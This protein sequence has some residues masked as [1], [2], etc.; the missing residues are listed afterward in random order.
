MRLRTRRAKYLAAIAA[1]A[2]LAASAA[3]AAVSSAATSAAAC[4][5]QYTVQNQWSTGFSLA[6][7]VT[8][9]GSPVTS[10]TLGYSYAGNQQLTEGWD[11]TWSQSGKNVTL[12]SA[13][14]N[15]S[16]G[17][18]GRTSAGANFSYSGT[19]A[20][21]TAFTLNGTTCST[22]AGPAPSP[23]PAPTATAEPTATAT[24]TPAPTATAAPSP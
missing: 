21:P 6:V 9:E 19:N 10:W 1:A 3:V 23:T 20:A 7:A 24:A 4:Q 18:G 17:T 11:G 15:G 16:L 2:G 5:V 14:W 22:S 8:N 13:S 12:T